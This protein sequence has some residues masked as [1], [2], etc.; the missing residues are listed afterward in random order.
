[1]ASVETRPRMTF[2]KDK[3]NRY[4]GK[5]RAKSNSNNNVS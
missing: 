2:K 3:K 5:N 4:N 1:M